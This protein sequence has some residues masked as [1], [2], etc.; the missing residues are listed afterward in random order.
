MLINYNQIFKKSIRRKVILMFV[1]PCDF[2]VGRAAELLSAFKMVVLLNT[3]LLKL[4][5]C[6]T[7]I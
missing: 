3:S 7:K 4:I 6:I 1:R 5:Y 2:D